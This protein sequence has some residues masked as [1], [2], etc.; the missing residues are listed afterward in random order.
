MPDSP[1][2]LPQPVAG[3][4]F[5]LDGTLVDTEE[6]HYDS[7]MSVLA[8]FGKSLGKEAFKP[9]I[10]T[11]EIPFWQDLRRLLD[12]APPVEE[13]LA[14]RTE[15]YLEILHTSSISP[16]PGVL[17]LLTWAQ[18]QG[19][20]MA[21]ASSSP[22]AQIDGTLRASG[23]GGFL[24]VRRSGH[25]DVAAGRGKPEPD[26]YLAAAAALGV[27]AGSCVAVEDSVTGM[28]AARAAGCYLFCVPN[29][30]F[31]PAHTDPAHAVVDSMGEVLARLRGHS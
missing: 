6:L 28:T 7:A 4:L 5:D 13:L 22:R 1:R 14:M 10:G 8:R 17:E 25:E 15:E 11:A 2:P 12:L 18:Q 23:L 30:T 27:D 29:P 19:L 9:Y 21:I 20:P 31:P 24:P 26:V 16:L 3:L